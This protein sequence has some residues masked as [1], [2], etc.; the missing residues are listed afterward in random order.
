MFLRVSYGG[1]ETAMPPFAEALSTADRWDVVFFLFAQRWP[2]CDHD[3]AVLSSS[4]LA[5]SRDFDLTD[6]VGY[7]S[8]GCVR[9]R[10]VGP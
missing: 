8:I 6:K 9:R 5:R 1:M 2:P 7:G 3:A 10:F 4:D